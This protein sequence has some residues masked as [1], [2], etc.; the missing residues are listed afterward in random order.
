LALEAETEVTKLPAHEQDYIR[1]QIAHN[2]KQ[3]Y[4]QY[5]RNKYC[6]TSHAKNEHHTLN[7]IREK[8]L[9]NN[10]LALKADKEILS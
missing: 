4:K 9:S 7:D 6:N 10:A 5:D 3:L 8:L 2:I 1:F